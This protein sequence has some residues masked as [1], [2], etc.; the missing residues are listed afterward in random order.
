MDTPSRPMPHPHFLHSNWHGCL[1][2]NLHIA[3]HLNRQ[4]FAHISAGI[5]I[6]SGGG[7]ADFTTKASM[8]QFRGFEHL[9]NM[10]GSTLD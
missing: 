5:S 6:C 8:F 2:Q 10:A 4:I 7:G 9:L 3:H 1:K